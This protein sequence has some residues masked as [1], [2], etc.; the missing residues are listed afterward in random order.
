MDYNTDAN[1]N[2]EEYR[3]YLNFFEEQGWELINSTFNGW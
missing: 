1:F 3:R 2:N